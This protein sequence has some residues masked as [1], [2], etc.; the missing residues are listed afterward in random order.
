MFIIIAGIGVIGS[1]VTKKLITN[2][3]DVVAIDIDSKV[4]EN[5]Y[6]ESGAVVIHGSA[7]DI[8]ILQEAGADKADILLCLMRSDSDNIACSLLGRSLGIPQIVG[9]LRNPLY[10]QAY[11]QAGVNSIIRMPD[12]LLNKI[13]IEVEKPKI[14]KVIELGKGKASVYTIKIPDKAKCI[15]KKTKEIAEN[16]R[17]FEECVFIGI[18]RE[19]NDEFKITR[20]ANI[21]QQDDVIFLISKNK[22]IKKATDYLLKV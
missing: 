13:I 6:S 3:H 15:G 17:F 19:K 1:Q 12:L 21:I 20:G 22:Y 10:E 14:R 8:K 7:T 16:K 4:C 2:K 5:I 9:C 18:Y 11:I